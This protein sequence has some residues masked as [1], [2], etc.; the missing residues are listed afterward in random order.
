M[1]RSNALIL[2]RAH[3]AAA[4]LAFNLKNPTF[5]KLFPHYRQRFV[6][7]CGRIPSALVTVSRAHRVQSAAHA[8]HDATPASPVSDDS[9]EASAAPAESLAAQQPPYDMLVVALI[10]TSLVFGVAYMLI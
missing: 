4:S 5:N 10:V 8:H 1:I 3:A 7:R 2:V 9:A 6:E